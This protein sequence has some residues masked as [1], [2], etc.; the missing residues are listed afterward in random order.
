MIVREVPHVGLTV[1][2]RVEVGGVS[3]AYVSDHQAPATDGAV[4]WTVS[5]S[6]LDLC[7]GADLLIHDAQYTEEEFSVKAHW[8]HSTLAYAVHVA[9]EAGAK[10]LALF[11]HDP[12]HDDR[13]LDMLGE[14][15]E[16]SVSGGALDAIIVAA[17][18]TTVS[19]AAETY[20]PRAPAASAR[21][22]DLR[23]ETRG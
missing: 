21:A 8:G 19:W 5:E 3:V 15:A 11:H 2:Y 17:E 7:D 22:P 13:T 20:E 9:K 16:D 4:S 10:R 6:V 18:G 14:A 23:N 1:G 12:T